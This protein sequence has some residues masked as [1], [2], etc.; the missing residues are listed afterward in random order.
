MNI[1]FTDK[2]SRYYNDPDFPNPQIASV[3]EASPYPTLLRRICN[4]LPP[5]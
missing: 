1:L 2:R 3:L 5:L 4:Y